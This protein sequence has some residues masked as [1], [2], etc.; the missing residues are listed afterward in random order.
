M[1]QFVGHQRGNVF[2]AKKRR[3][4]RGQEPVQRIARGK[5]RAALTHVAIVCDDPTIQPKLP[6]ILLT[7]GHVVRKRDVQTIVDNLPPN[8]A[9][10][11]EKSSWTNTDIMCRIL[12]QLALALAPHGHL[13]PILSLD[14]ARQHLNP[15]IAAAAARYGI[16]IYMIPAGLTWLLQPCDT[17]V[18]SRYKRYLGARLQVAKSCHPQKDIT[19]L[20][21]I[22]CIS[23][24][25]RKVMQGVSWK[26]AFAANGMTQHQSEVSTYIKAAL[27]IEEVP[28]VPIT[29]PTDEQLAVIFPQNANVK[30]RVFFRPFAPADEVAAAVALENAAA[31]AQ[32]IPWALRS[33]DQAVLPAAPPCQTLRRRRLSI[34]A[35]APAGT[36]AA[37]PARRRR[38]R[39][40]SSGTTLAPA[41]TNTPPPTTPAAGPATRT[42]PQAPQTNSQARFPLC[43]PAPGT[44][45]TSA[46]SSAATSRTRSGAGHAWSRPPGP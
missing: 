6:Q 14:C 26:R 19:T 37:Q 35:R 29:R 30:T 36:T 2:Y 41:L 3:G 24:T 12:G 5:T 10:W 44:S 42:P 7:N 43:E 28:D 22:Q 11:R 8:I 31:A 27:K 15:R 25:I 13:Q 39:V 32:P 17:H 18:F 46:S 9:L 4:E 33:A 34:M 38:I 1:N 40:V 21:W 20:A 45:G 16:W 23:T